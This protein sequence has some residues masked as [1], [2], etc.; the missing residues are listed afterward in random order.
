M[1]EYTDYQSSSTSIY[2]PGSFS[3]EEQNMKSINNV[4]EKKGI[5][6]KHDSNNLIAISL[7]AKKIT[8]CQYNQSLEYIIRKLKK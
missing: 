4:F 7:G 8:Y 3:I 1:K 2:K 6:Q 5:S